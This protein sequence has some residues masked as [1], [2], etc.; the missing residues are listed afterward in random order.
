MLNNHLLKGCM[1]HEIQQ[2]VMPKEDE[3]M[4][5]QKH[6]KK[7]KCPYVIYGDFVCLT[8]P[9][10]EGIK[11][12][13]QHHKPC[14]FM[15]NVVNSIFNEAT[16]YL[17]RGENCMD[18]FCSS[19]NKTKEEIM[20]KMKENGRQSNRKSIK[21]KSIALYAVVNS[22]RKTPLKQRQPTAATLWDN[23]GAPHIT[24]VL[25]SKCF[26]ITLK[27]MMLA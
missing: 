13:Y 17:Y 8:T 22:T 1:A 14:G 11:G 6:Y 5:F 7:L 27:S 20:D 19:I 26:F 16:P 15:L 9:S 4:S 18:R 2:V 24:N 3:K 25:K 10:L 12:T 21:R 23:I